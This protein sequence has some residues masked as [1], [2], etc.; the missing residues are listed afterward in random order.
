MRKEARDANQIIP[1]SVI[2]QLDTSFGFSP[3]LCSG[4]WVEAFISWHFFV[5]VQA[6][7]L[8]RV[9]YQLPSEQLAKL[10]SLAVSNILINKYD[11]SISVELKCFIFTY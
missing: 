3:D 8:H 1:F 7:R 2:S 10:H 6:V 11:R 9:L 5:M 4:G